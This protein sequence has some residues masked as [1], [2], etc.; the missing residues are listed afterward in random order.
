M[1]EQAGYVRYNLSVSD[2]IPYPC[3]KNIY[4]EGTL[5]ELMKIHIEK[6]IK[7]YTL[8]DDNEPTVHLDVE[9]TFHFDVI[10]ESIEVDTIEEEVCDFL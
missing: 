3:L 2:F 7:A 1:K 5:E 8:T 4:G 9:D 6:T 10:V